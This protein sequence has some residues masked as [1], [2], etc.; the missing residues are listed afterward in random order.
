MV[1]TIQ[2][3]HG[4]RQHHYTIDMDIPVVRRDT[5][6]P[7]VSAACSLRDT[8]STLC[9]DLFRAPRAALGGRWRVGGHWR[10]R[11]TLG[12][13]LL[14]LLAIARQHSEADDVPDRA[15]EVQRQAT[16]AS[17]GFEAITH[18]QPL[19]IRAKLC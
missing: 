12:F 3:T 17:S 16:A 6:R 13:W 2:R 4:Q 19:F 1:A 15:D 9:A 8:S 18:R 14:G 7:P 5:D 10:R 11:A